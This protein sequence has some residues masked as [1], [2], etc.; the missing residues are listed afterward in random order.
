MYRVQG[1][2][3]VKWLDI[4]DRVSVRLDRIKE[5]AFSSHLQLSPSKETLIRDYIK[6]LSP[7][8]LEEFWCAL[9]LGSKLAQP[10]LASDILAYLSNI[11]V[12]CHYIVKSRF[13]SGFGTTGKMKRATKNMPIFSFI[14]FDRLYTTFVDGGDAPPLS[15]HF[16]RGHI[17]HLWK[18]SGLNRH[19]IPNDP[20]VRIKLAHAHKVRRVYIP[21]TW[22]GCQHYEDND[23]RH[24]IITQEMPLREL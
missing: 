3:N 16:R 6:Y 22:V 23:C 13:K 8:G 20:I 21:P 15:P 10:G 17:R 14:T 24:E 12:P 4:D 11:C 7:H 1:S 18:E 9:E 19:L 5:A 2:V